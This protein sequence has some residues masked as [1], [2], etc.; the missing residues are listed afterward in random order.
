MGGPST[1]CCS[2]WCDETGPWSRVTKRVF[3]VPK[4]TCATRNIAPNRRMPCAGLNRRKIT[5]VLDID[6]RWRAVM[7]C[8]LHPQATSYIPCT[9]GRLGLALFKTNNGLRRPSDRS[10]P[11]VLVHYGSGNAIIQ[12]D[13]FNGF[14]HSL[15]FSP[16]GTSRL[17]ALWDGQG[18]SGRGEWWTGRASHAANENRLQ[19]RT[20]NGPRLL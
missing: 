16:S 17:W 8:T 14:G 1:D 18:Q 12:V 3:H 9:R 19:R 2:F 7:W 11:S 20:A 15:L 13:P 5:W 6:R 10:N 4:N